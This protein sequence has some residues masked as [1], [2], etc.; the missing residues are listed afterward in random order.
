MTTA[1]PGR[2]DKTDRRVLMALGSGIVATAVAVA[3]YNPAL[4]SFR[5]FT[6]TEFVSQM[7]PLVMVSLFIERVLEVFLTSWRAQRLVD[8][9][10]DATTW[11]RHQTRRIAFFGGTALGVIMAVLG[12]GSD[13]LHQMVLVFTNFMASAATRVKGE[14]IDK[15]EG[16][17]GR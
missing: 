16:E 5:A 10:A 17:Q 1:I 12:G 4:L 6:A 11:H 8:L 14:G 3:L 7:L 9:E 13:A 2:Y 15:R